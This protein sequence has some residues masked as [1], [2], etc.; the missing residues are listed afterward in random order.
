MCDPIK[1]LWLETFE[2]LHKL[3]SLPNEWTAERV[4]FLISMSLPQ[5]VRS[6]CAWSPV[7]AKL[8]QVAFGKEWYTTQYD[9]KCKLTLPAP[10]FNVWINDTMVRESVHKS[11]IWWIQ[12]ANPLIS[13]SSWLHI[14]QGCIDY[15]LPMLHQ[16]VMTTVLGMESMKSPAL[17]GLV[18]SS[19]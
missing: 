19:F 1:R 12:H 11:I 16:E 2:R 13:P 15:Y 18:F 5:S 9:S 14:L 10:L 3:S 6:K 7:P 17:R 8:R 4:E